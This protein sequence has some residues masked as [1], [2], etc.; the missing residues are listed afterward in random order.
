MK[1]KIRSAKTLTLFII[2][3]I[4]AALFLNV[5]AL[6]DH[7]LTFDDYVME[8]IATVAPAPTQVYVEPTATPVVVE[9][10]EETPVPVAAAPQR[11]FN[12]EGVFTDGEI[13]QT[14]NSYKSANISVTL[15]N[16][17]P[18]DK[19]KQSYF[20][21]DIYVSDI[22]YISCIFAQDTVAA[23]V[24]EKFESMA[25]RSNSIA[26]INTDF[27]G[28]SKNAKGVVIRN[29]KL[30]RDTLNPNDDV[31]VLFMDGTMQ[32][33]QAKK[34]PSPQSLIDMGAWQAFS[35]GPILLVD[36]KTLPSY[37][38]KYMD[39]N[40]RSVFGYV[41]PG[42]YKFIVCDGGTDGYAKGQTIK[43]MAQFAQSE[44][45][46]MAYNLDGGQSTQ[47]GFMGSFADR[48]EKGGRS[49]SD[50]LIVS[51]NLFE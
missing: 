32:M 44:G 17:I 4:L 15:K 1:K 8:P 9:I 51:E 43:L 28:H 22:R 38:D 16:V 5:F 11:Q 34:V 25:S 14:E 27:Y 42:H 46:V 41:E 13:I 40:P 33:Y 6:F 37:P 20:V 19:Y 12:F 39:R 7:V 29:G 24:T 45:C 48:P 18:S 26:A 50:I 23:N 2:D 30:Y 3:A 36:G 10:P 31:M 35:F 21:E 49:V 47:L